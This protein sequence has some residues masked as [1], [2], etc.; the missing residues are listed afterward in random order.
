MV[1]VNTNND[2]RAAKF[3]VSLGKRK[4]SVPVERFAKHKCFCFNAILENVDFDFHDD[5][6]V[7]GV[8]C[9]LACI[10]IGC[11]TPLGFGEI[12]WLKAVRV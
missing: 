12:S 2:W 8:N 4:R 7:R 9:R 5:D 10:E 3:G 11:L 6:L 1:S